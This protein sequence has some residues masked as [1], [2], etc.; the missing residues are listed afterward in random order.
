MTPSPRHE[1]EPFGRAKS[2]F[3]NTTARVIRRFVKNW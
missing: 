1:E 3:F 2:Y